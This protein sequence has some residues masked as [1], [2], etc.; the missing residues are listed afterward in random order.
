MEI[1]LQLQEPLPL[2]ED[3]ARQLE[4][5]GV[6]GLFTMEAS[7]DP[8]LPLAKAGR[9]GRTLY[10][11]NA[12]IAL[13]RNPLH[14]AYIANDLQNLTGGRFAMGLAP[15]IQA[16]IEGRFGARFDPPVARMR[17]FVAA[18]RAIRQSWANSTTLSFDGVFYKHTFMPPHFAPGPP[19]FPAPPVYVAAL[20]PRMTQMAAEVAD[21]ILIHPFATPRFVMDEMLPIINTVNPDRTTR[22]FAV[23]CG[24]LVGLV[25]RHTD[26]ETLNHRV[27]QT[28]G[29]YA[30]TP[31]YR[32]VLDTHSL[33]G[34]QEKLREL[35]SQQRWG[36][37]SRHISDDMLHTFALIGHPHEV[38][39][40]LRVRFGAIADRVAVY[41]QND[42]ADT[43]AVAE[44]VR[45]YRMLS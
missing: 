36:E 26:M 2:V 21:G 28:I 23:I 30:T 1:D 22:P 15:Q 39:E 10:Y 33:Y 20:G 27:R 37:L 4:Q 29:F 41:L 44:L 18:L 17:E 40:Q 16:H 12:A 14:V 42:R 24:A 25:D 13:S 43:E 35:A 9:N 31:A 32:R 11:T 8:F 3:T 45:R 5:A 7:S 19:P 38:A 34:L 6:D